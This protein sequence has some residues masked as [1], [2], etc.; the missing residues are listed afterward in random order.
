[1]NAAFSVFLP[2]LVGASRKAIQANCPTT[3]DTSTAPTRRHLT[4]PKAY[5]LPFR[6]RHVSNRAR[7][8][9]HDRPVANLRDSKIGQPHMAVCENK[10]DL[11]FDVAVNDLHVVSIRQSFHQLNRPFQCSPRCQAPRQACIQWFVTHQGDNYKVAINH[12]RV[13]DAE[14]VWMVQFRHRS[15][16]LPKRIHHRVIDQMRVGNL[17][18]NANTLDRIHRAIDGCKTAV[19]NL[20]FQCGTFPASVERELR[21]AWRSS[22]WNS[23]ESREQPP[24]SMLERKTKQT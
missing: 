3:S 4:L 6:A 16:F 11:G 15:Y 21:Q 22:V 1:M 12:T 9:G 23:F 7:P 24:V 20:F 13:L 18:G 8:I 10:N 17:N 5:S 2:L 19:A 14:N